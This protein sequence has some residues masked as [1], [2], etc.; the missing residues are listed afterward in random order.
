MSYNELLAKAANSIQLPALALP[1]YTIHDTGFYCIGHQLLRVYYGQVLRDN[2]AYLLIFQWLDENGYVD[3]D[4]NNW[5]YRNCRNLLKQ[6]GIE[7]DSVSI[8]GAS[9]SLTKNIGGPAY[10]GP[11][12]IH[13]DREVFNNLMPPDKLGRPSGYTIDRRFMIS[14]KEEAFEM[15]ID[16]CLESPGIEGVP[17]FS[18]LCSK[19]CVAQQRGLQG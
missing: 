16:F 4:G 9:G 8:I 19:S 6:I 15:Y 18:A 1:R 12:S 2:V 11:F 17:D 5:P 14:L 10:I 13:E 3:I 7:S